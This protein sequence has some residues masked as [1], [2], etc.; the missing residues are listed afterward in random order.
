[1]SG[2]FNPGGGH[3]IGAKVNPGADEWVPTISGNA[4]LRLSMVPAGAGPALRM[5]YVFN[6][7]GGFVVARRAFARSMPAEYA[8]RFRLRGRGTVHALEL[9]LIDDTN[10]NVWRHVIANLTPSARWKGVT[11]ESRA[12]DFAWGPASGRGVSQLGFVEFAI[13]A[14]AA[15]AGTLSIADLA[16]EDRTPTQAPLATASSALPDFAAGDALQ[17]TGWKPLAEDPRP[18]IS[19]DLIQPRRLGGLTIEWLGAAPADGFRV[20][21]SSGGK[22]W[23]T[24]YT[25]KR[26]GGRRAYVYLPG[27]DTRCVRL[28]FSEPIDGATLQLQ[29]FDFSRSIDDFWYHVAAAE[30]RGFYP[31]WLHREQTLWTPIGTAHGTE[32]ALMNDDG[33]VEVSQGSFSLEPMLWIGGML[34]TWADVAAQ[35]SLLDGW[36][37]VPTVRWSHADWNLYIQAQTTASGDLRVRYRFE[38]L[39]AAAI[40][41]RLFVLVRPFQVT[42]PWQSFRGLGGVKKIHDVSWRDGA[43]WVDAAARIVPMD[44]A[45]AAGAA[46]AAWSFGANAF[47]DGGIALQLC[48]GRPPA[49]A[50]AHDVFGF[51]TGSFAFEL[52]VAANQS[53]ERALSCLPAAAVRSTAALDGGGASLEPAFDWGARMPVSQWSGNG[54]VMDAIRAALTATAHILVTRDGPALQPGPRRYTR[55]WIRDGAMMSA[56]LLRMGYIDAVRQFIAWYAPHQR[57]DGFVPCCVDREGIDWLVEHDSHGE[58][59][60]LIADYHRFA[61]DPDF[62]AGIWIHVERAAG[63]IERLLGPD[64]LLPISVSHEGYLAQ[65]VHAYWD[66]FWA[67][68]GLGDA[69]FLARALG[70]EEPAAHWQTLAAR[71]AASLYSSIEATRRARHLEF[72]PGSVEWADFDPTA[73]ANAVYLLGVPRGLDRRALERTFDQ[74]LADWHNKRSGAVAALNYTP[75]EIRIIGALVRLGRRDAALVLLRFF[76]DDRRPRAWNQWPEIAWRDGHA[77]AHVGDLPHTWI[78]AEYVLA[79]RSLF[80]YEREADAAADAAA[81]AMADATADATVEAAIVVAAGLA[82]E[83]IEGA[84]VVVRGMPTLYGPLSYTLR[85]VDANTLHFTLEGGIGARVILTPP[86]A[87]PL[88]AVVVDGRTCENFDA[89][90]VTI[91]QSDQTSTFILT[92]SR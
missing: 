92:C 54:W 70:R 81:D 37:P 48:S 41:A 34:V 59:L 57:A 58:L 73:T 50:A 49:H 13:V 87:A 76:L 55:S 9:K 44:A 15:G 69:V 10:Q 8:L 4:E 52:A 16:I 60:A 23:K 80:A 5:D 38:N 28:E 1:M 68:R 74:Y 42:P 36:M 63:C 62:L 22:R 19:L 33:M 12:I 2:R 77:P 53:A 83:W 75:Y 65:P 3:A 26:A 88:R 40:A 18:W 20:L 14:V 25:A 11:V 72:I 32:C 17:P 21:A 47:D 61:Q 51:A 89:G 30:P 79:L 6:D 71:F 56:A 86:L 90:S 43:V 91:H 84:G 46:G 24:V 78:A 39:T 82:P 35:A 64:G 45:G 29:P 27:L 85:R 31:R 67:L 7:A 66:D